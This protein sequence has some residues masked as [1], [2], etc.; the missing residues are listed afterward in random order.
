ML[1]LERK[2]GWVEGVTR[3]KM[4]ERL[5]VVLGRA[6]VQ[7]VFSRLEGIPSLVCRL[8]Y[9]SGLR[10]MEALELRVKDL[11]LDRC[12]LRHPPARGRLRHPHHP[13]SSWATRMSRPP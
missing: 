13:R 1:A 10:L 12:E 8:L 7:A 6:E 2:L 4:P 9:G 3:A 11:D 5:P